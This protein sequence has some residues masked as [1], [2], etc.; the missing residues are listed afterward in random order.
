MNRNYADGE[1][2]SST[3]TAKAAPR[4]RLKSV[5]F[6][7]FCWGLVWERRPL[8][9]QGEFDVFVHNVLC[10]EITYEVAAEMAQGEG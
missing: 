1:W 3:T 8:M 10:F 6:T 5:Q 4:W 9:P 2:T 7:P